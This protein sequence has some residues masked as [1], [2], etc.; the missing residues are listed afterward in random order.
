MLVTQ[1]VTE[2]DSPWGGREP[3]PVLSGNLKQ[4]K[5]IS[6]ARMDARDFN[7]PWVTSHHPANILIIW[8]P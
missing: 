1:Q 8:F 5:C 3:P 6:N 4:A 2:V 7:A